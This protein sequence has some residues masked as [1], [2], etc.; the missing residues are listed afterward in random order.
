MASL[1]EQVVT[2][3]G[4]I[5]SGGVHYAVNNLQTITTPYIVILRVSSV[6]NVALGGPSDL[7]N[8]RLQVDIYAKTVAEIDA[9]GRQ[10]SA[11]FTGWSVKNVPLLTMDTF[12]PD[13][14]LFHTVK[15]F[16]IWCID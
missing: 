7:Q 1:I 8:T 3:L 4:G 13:T 10:V 9:L 12:E 11:A 15:D 6:Q 14:K 16:S 5:A 2:L